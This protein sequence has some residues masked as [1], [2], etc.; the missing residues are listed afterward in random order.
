MEL[1]AGQELVIKAIM[2]ETSCPIGFECYNSK[3]EKLCPARQL[4]GTNLVECQSVTGQ[5]CLMST[6]YGQ[7]EL[8]CGCQLR[9]FVAVELET[10]HTL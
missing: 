10:S 2:A 6:V 5:E 8:V 1:S 3:F 9:N 7:E 4:A